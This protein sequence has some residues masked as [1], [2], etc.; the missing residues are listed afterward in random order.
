MEVLIAVKKDNGLIHVEHSATKF[1][2]ELASSLPALNL[3]DMQVAVGM[4]TV[5]HRKSA[6]S[7]CSIYVYNRTYLEGHW[8][9]GSIQ[10]GLLQTCAR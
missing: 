9:S 4:D 2:Y 7:L 8:R 1:Q 10:F 5:D 3:S 6:G